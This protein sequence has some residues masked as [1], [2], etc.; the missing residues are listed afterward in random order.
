MAKYATRQSANKAKGPNQRVVQDGKGFK[1]VAT[2]SLAGRASTTRTGIQPKPLAKPV[3]NSGKG[4]GNSKVKL[5]P[6]ANSDKGT[7][8]SGAKIKPTT[9]AAQGVRTRARVLTGAGRQ[10]GP[11]TSKPAAARAAASSAKKSVK[12]TAKRGVGAVRAG[13]ATL[14]TKRL[15]AKRDKAARNLTKGSVGGKGKSYS[16]LTSKQKVAMGGGRRGPSETKRTTSQSIGV[17]KRSVKKAATT[18][19]TT[20]RSWGSAAQ[21]AAIRKLAE[22]NRGR[23]RAGKAITRKAVKY[24]LA[25]GARYGGNSGK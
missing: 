7:G 2:N 3:A 6:V 20:A 17:A 12:R 8:R 19:G 10:D 9:S 1:L 16:Q 15:K 11:N 22:F 21:K 18:A 4:T 14:K 24:G 5:K 23:K 13:I 25:S